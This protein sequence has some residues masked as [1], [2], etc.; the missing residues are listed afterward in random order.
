MVTELKDAGVLVTPMVESA[1]NRVPRHRFIPE[2]DVASAYLDR[3]VVVKHGQ[4]GAAI[5]SASQPAMVAIMLE[6][7]SLSPGQRVLEIGTGTGYNAALLAAIVGP[8]GQVVSIELEPDLARRARTILTELAT[9]PV[10]VVLGDGVEG[11]ARRGPYDRVIVTTGA[12][13]IA[14]A[15]RDQLAEGGRLVVPLVGERGAGTVVDF[16]KIDGLLVRGSET[17]C[18]FLPMRRLPDES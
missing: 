10:E 1:M 3:A 14:S 12:P 11:F 15:W 17:P 5:S 6:R 9:G 7:L 2:V 8:Q 16:Q 13:E 4:D 18:G